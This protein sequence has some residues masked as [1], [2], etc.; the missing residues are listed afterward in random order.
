VGRYLLCGEIGRGGMGAVF[1]V[2]DLE[3]DRELALKVLLPRDNDPTQEDRFLGEARIAAR[4]QHPGI[5]PVHEVG[6]ADDNR[7][8]FTMKLVEGQTLSHLLADRPS[9]GHDLPRFL[10]IFESVCRTLAFAHSHK[11]I[12]RDLKPANIM[13]GP[14]GEVQV[15]DWGL[16]KVLAEPHATTGT[17]LSPS[18]PTRSGHTHSGAVLG[19]P[20]YMAPEQARPQGREPD[21]RTDVFGLGAVLCEIL[22]GQPPF[23]APSSDAALELAA[24]ADLTGVHQR[25]ASCGADPELVTLATACLAADPNDRPADAAVV[26][27][28]ISSF[29]ANG[30]Q[31]LR[32]AELERAAAQGRLR[33]ERR[34]RH[35]ALIL[36]STIFLIVLGSG[37]L[38]WWA[39][40]RR[41]A[42]EHQVR[43]L[44]TGADDRL[45]RAGDS[46]TVEQLL[47]QYHEARH[48]TEQARTAVENNLAG[49]ALRA[50][51]ATPGGP[52]RRDRLAGAGT[53]FPPP[54][55]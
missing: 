23:L 49:A 9:P 45:R 53:G 21:Q 51:R 28:C 12:H 33:L 27:Q 39:N 30:E 10:S 6:R 18:R 5:V 44:L 34:S 48:L 46:A 16:A 1:R 17:A 4:L 24:Q 8:Y 22:T 2:R 3:L 32:K 25:L 26:D 19:T 50:G 40:A 47:Q 11:V 7:P 36:I 42:T 29:R 54:S 52:R 55:V 43:E 37:V 38:L 41:E 15:M 31:R 20:C 13:V 35:L 14:F